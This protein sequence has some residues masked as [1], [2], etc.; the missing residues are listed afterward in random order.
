MQSGGIYI[1]DFDGKPVAK[2]DAPY[3]SLI[4]GSAAGTRATPVKLEAGKP[5]YFAVV[6]EFDFWQRS[7]LSV[8]DDAGTLTYQEV[9]DEACAAIAAVPNEDETESLYL[10][11]TGKVWK[12]NV[13]TP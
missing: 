9:F 2:F 3:V 13:A 12:Y 1:I 6:V 11:A 5:T 7:V 10:G 8:Y 4:G